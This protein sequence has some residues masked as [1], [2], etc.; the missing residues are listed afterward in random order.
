MGYVTVGQFRQCLS[1]LGLPAGTEE[2]VAMETWF[3]DDKGFNYLRFLEELQPSKR[4]E[5]AYQT[6]LRALR[7]RDGQVRGGGGG[8]GSGD[9][10]VSI[11]CHGDTSRQ[12]VVR[13]RWLTQNKCWTRSR[14]RSGGR[15]EGE[16]EG[17]RGRGLLDYSCIT[18]LVDVGYIFIAEGMEAK[19]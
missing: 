13:G 1:Q 18:R 7:S 17:G 14:P 12:V 8:T 19:T 10:R 5:D 9:G 2:T 16:G 3:S 15:G 6:R 11:S 4:L